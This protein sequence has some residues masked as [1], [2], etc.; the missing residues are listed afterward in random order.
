MKLGDHRSGRTRSR[1]PS[2]AGRLRVPPAP[3]APPP[4]AETAAGPRSP[5]A[6]RAAPV[7]PGGSPLDVACYACPCGYV[8]DALV[9]TTVQ[10]PNCGG[11]QD[12]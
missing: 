8:F 3:P 10:C 4:S 5:A 1:R 6:G 2:L 9:T 11:E 12:W 7:V